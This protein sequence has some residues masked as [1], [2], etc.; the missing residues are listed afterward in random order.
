[1]DDHKPIDVP[2]APGAEASSRYETP[3][4][5]R[6]LDEAEAARAAGL[7]HNE[8]IKIASGFLRGT[9]A[10]GLLKHATGA[11]SDDDGQLVKFHGMY[12]QDDRD[13]RPE[14][15]K[16]KL[17]KAYSFMIRL[18][19]AGGV[20]TPQQWL[21]LDHIATTYANGTL[22]ATTR[23]TFQYHG[24][25]KSNLKRTMKE[26]DAALLDTIAACGD[27][28]RNVMAATN[29][30]Q[31]GAHKAAY[32]LGKAISDTLLPK[33]N[34]W[35]EIWLDGEKVV[36]GEEEFVEPV[37]GK[38][39]LPRKFKIVVAVP[40]SNEVDVFAHDLGFIAIL[41]KK[42]RVTGWNVTVGGGMGSTHGETDTFPRTADVMGFCKPEDALK[43]AEA[44]MTVQRDW[45]N[46]KV[47]KNARLKYTIERFG[48]AA[49]RAEVEKRLGKPL[50]EAKPFRFENNVDRYGWTEGD[51]GRH[52]L[53]LY[54]PSGR[55][56]DVKDGPQF[57][58]GLRR[59]AEVHEG[60]FRLTGNQNVIVA[61]VSAGKRA[62]IEAL[63]DAHALTKGAGALRRSSIACVALPTCG[64]ALAESERYL[65]SLI[66]ELEESLAEHGLSEKE[67]TIRMT[68]CPNGCARPF[69]AE[70]GLVGR[71]PE[72]YH[73]YLGAAH[74]GSRL[75]KLYAP[76]IAASEV[77]GALDPLFADYARQRRDGEHFGDFLIRAGHVARTGNGP[78][79]HANT[80]ALKPA[81]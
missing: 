19:I 34:A 43:V 49:F 3:P 22:R 74:D 77:R 2:E 36:G 79:F 46:R 60:D 56:A 61:N 29:P 67:I 4:T 78:D 35:R 64:L 17:D 7:S 80:G 39:Y 6:P 62:E 25:I 70:I 68:G 71:G 54:V 69:I 73:L 63:V 13:L 58:T 66:D 52:H 30:A 51:D 42:N 37:Y 28:N 16:K 24:V 81:V 26:I 9:L 41:D 47:R 20:V 5:G 59:I 31:A 40:P 38:T 11:I 72:R 33:T 23:Q 45:G 44:V 14:R 12:L 8:H 53:T 21:V 48:L 75:S 1:M 55:I 27:V 65:P 50:A 15:A 57:L 10:D 18:R 32:D 76:D